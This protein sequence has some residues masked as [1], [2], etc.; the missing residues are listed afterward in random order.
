[1]PSQPPSAPAKEESASSGS[2]LLIDYAALPAELNGGLHIESYSLEIDDGEGGAFVAL[3]GLAVPSLATSQLITTGVREGV[4]YRVRYRAR[5]AYGWGPYSVTAA[6]LAA[7]A[8]AQ[9]PTAPGVVSVS[10]TD[11]QVRLDL[12]VAN[13]GAPIT[14]YSLEINEGGLLNDVF[15]EVASYD[16]TASL[17]LHT[18]NIVTD[19]LVYGTIYKLRFRAQNLV[20]TGE[21][22]DVTLVALTAVPAAPPTPTRVESSSSETS[23]AVSWA[24]M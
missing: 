12:G 20:G 23:V 7:Q 8:P 9:P 24:D 16:G 21:P 3:T 18:L 19:S 13:G 5:N 17:Q 14:A 10:D 11:I 6:I 15:S 4:T 2:R 22:S 1:V